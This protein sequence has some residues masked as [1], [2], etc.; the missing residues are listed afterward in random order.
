MPLVSVLK[1]AFPFLFLWWFL[2]FLSYVG[3][4]CMKSFCCTWS[5]LRDSETPREVTPCTSFHLLTT[6]RLA[7]PCAVVPCLLFAPEL[8]PSCSPVQQTRANGFWLLLCFKSS[9]ASLGF[10][11]KVWICWV[12]RPAFDFILQSGPPLCSVFQS[13]KT[14]SSPFQGLLCLSPVCSLLCLWLPSLYL[15]LSMTSSGKAPWSSLN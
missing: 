7:C 4:V 14:S 6:S 1:I 13:Q 11:I 8:L 2:C 10:K 3:E 12:S 9:V 15:E 5:R